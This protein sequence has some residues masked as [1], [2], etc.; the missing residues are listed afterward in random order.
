MDDF[1]KVY[2]RVYAVTGQK[3]WA[4]RF[5]GGSYNNHNRDTADDII[6]EMNSRGFAYYDW[7]SATS[8]ASS[9]ATYDSCVEYFR[10]SINADHE[11][12]LMHDSLELTPQYLQDIIDH[13][14]SEGY[15]FETVATADVIQF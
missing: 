14:I 10:E 3:P 6:S 2:G 1:A 5:P 9:D 15:S 13:L 4:F 11:V 12:V 8:D 7:N